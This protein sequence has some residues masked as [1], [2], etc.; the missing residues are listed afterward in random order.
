VAKPIKK[1]KPRYGSGFRIKQI[2]GMIIGAFL[3]AAILFG[4]Y[5][6]YQNQGTVSTTVSESNIGEKIQTFIKNSG[7]QSS[8]L[9]IVAI[10]GMLIAYIFNK[11]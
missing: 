11:K 7:L 6:I 10:G 3:F 1:G 5:W 4:V 9:L 2:L 8:W